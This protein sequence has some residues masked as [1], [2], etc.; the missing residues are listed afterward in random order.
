[1]RDEE[2]VDAVVAEARLRESKPA[3]LAPAVAWLRERSE[4]R[5]T[6]RRSDVPA[7]DLADLA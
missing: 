3:T 4:A 6:L 2:A 1:M 7:S 5:E